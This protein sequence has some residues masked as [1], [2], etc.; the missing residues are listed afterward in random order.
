KEFAA[1]G[2][3]IRVTSNANYFFGAPVTNA[4]V[5]YYIYKQRYYHWWWDNDSDEF[6][7]AA[8]PSNEEDDEEASDYYSTD[9]VTEED[10]ALNARG[11]AYVEF[12]VP[13]P[14]PKE[15]WDYSYRL[16]AQVTD[17]SR[18]EMTGAA[19]LI[20]TRAKTVADA[21]PERYLYSQGDAATIRVKTADYA[22]KPISEKVTLKFIEQTWERQSKWE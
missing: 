7:D 5:H 18:R 4:E 10:A 11:E 8:G 14:D 17:A 19:S 22:G 12:E 3:K 6:D 15:E 2:E 9:L 16:E 13:A 20:G 21:Y 1:V